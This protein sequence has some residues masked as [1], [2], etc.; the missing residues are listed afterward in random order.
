VENGAA[1]MPIVV[2]EGAPPFTRQAAEELAEYIEKTSGARPEVLEGQPDPLPDSA[3]WVGHQPIL[4]TLFPDLDFDFQHPEE[5]LIAANDQHL[6]IAGRDRWDPEHLVVTFKRHTVNGVQQEYGTVN[7]VYTF[8]QDYL[9]VRWLWP[10]ESGEDVLQQATIAFEPFVYRYHPR[11]RARSGVFNIYTLDRQLRGHEWTRYQRLQLDSLAFQA[12]HPFSDWWER[13]HETHPDYFALQPDGTRG[14]GEKPY[15]SARMVK[16]CKSNPDLWEQWLK[17]VEEEL[18]SNPN[19]TTFGANANDGWGAGY[20]ICDSCRAWD[21][22]DGAVFR[23]S[24]QGLSQEYV[25]MSDRQITF[26]NT[27]ARKLRERFPDRE[28]LLVTAMAYGDSRTPPVAAEPDDNVLVSGV[29]SFHNQPNDEHREWFVQWS[30]VAPILAWRPNMSSRAGWHIGLPNAA[31]RRVMEDM[32][33]VAEHNVVGVFIDSVYGGWA[34]QG[35]HYYMLAQMAW[36]PYADGEAILADYYQR[37]FGPAA[38]TMAGYW[39]AITRA[40]ERI[41][42]EGESDRDVWDAAFFEDATA[43]LDQAATEA[44]TDET[45]VYAERVA[46]VRVGLEYLRLL[47]EMDPLIDRMAETRGRD[48]EARAAAEAKWDETW[49]VIGAM[50]RAHPLSIAPFYVQ[51]RWHRLERWSPERFD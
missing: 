33:F 18:E 26:A 24:W 15:P 31:P 41:G 36:N 43:R 16:M 17:V 12:G 30:K 1:R 5:I 34:G 49:E 46:F 27:L 47:R 6:V 8:L 10:G 19:R 48:P 35:P 25:A 7:A 20:C 39:E 32:R 42:F 37:A 2:F 38:E 28:D 11:F 23:I 14:G 13:F 29:W 4:D 45:A 40:A 51:R 44:A 22:P 9:G 50:M 3:I 21:H